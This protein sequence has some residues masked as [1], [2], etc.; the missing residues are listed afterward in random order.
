MSADSNLARA[1]YVRNCCRFQGKTEEAEGLFIRGL[2]TLEA[3]HGP[4]HPDVAA[5]LSHY[6][7][8]LHQEVRG[9]RVWFVGGGEIYLL[10]ASPGGMRF[11]VLWC[12]VPNAGQIFFTHTEWMCPWRGHVTG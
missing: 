9:V 2:A 11:C 5:V 3:A 8:M 7:S 12:P 6:A 10:A 1:P 4:E